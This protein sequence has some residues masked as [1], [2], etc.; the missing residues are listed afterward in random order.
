MG[1]EEGENMR[2]DEKGEPFI[3]YFYCKNGKCRMCGKKTDW[4]EAC[5]L[6]CEDCVNKLLSMDIEKRVSTLLSFLGE[7]KKHES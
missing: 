1:E 5:F 4:V 3:V 6:I 7:K 2:V